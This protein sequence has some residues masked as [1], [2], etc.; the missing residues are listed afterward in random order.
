MKDVRIT[1]RRRT[2]REYEAKL[3]IAGSERTRRF[4]AGTRTDAL[5]LA[6]RA[7]ERAEQSWLHS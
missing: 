2:H 5:Q 7:V 3:V 6:V 4:R 1:V